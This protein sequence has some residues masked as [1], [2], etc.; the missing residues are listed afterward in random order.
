MLRAINYGVIA[1]LGLIALVVGMTYVQLG[2]NDSRLQHIDSKLLSISTEL[3]DYNAKLEALN[4]R[5]DSLD[6]MLAEL[7]DKAA[8]Q[9]EETAKLKEEFAALRAEVH[10]YDI[11]PT[12][13]PKMDKP[14]PIPTLAPTAPGRA[15]T[16][17]ENGLGGWALHAVGDNSP[18][19]AGY[20]APYSYY[21]MELTRD[22]SYHIPLRTA[23]PYQTTT[24]A[25]IHGEGWDMGFGIANIIDVSE[26]SRLELSF[27]AKVAG[28]NSI[29]YAPDG[30]PNLRV[31]IL[32]DTHSKMV[33]SIILVGHSASDQVEDN[34]HWDNYR[35]DLTPYIQS[36]TSLPIMI[37]QFD[38]WFADGKQVLWVDNIEITSS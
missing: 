8:M 15:S 23:D 2:E 13:A 6:G 14:T 25:K 20:P 7:N 38:S 1:A 3:K 16:N 18:G 10:R 31:V 28:L 36:K 32:D 27:D 34:G 19:L 21:Q 12:P 17:F 29:T 5:T 11:L 22:D 30:I 9:A 37:M 24:H 33:R 35:V 4:E 26:T